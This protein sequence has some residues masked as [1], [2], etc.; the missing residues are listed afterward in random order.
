[1]KRILL[2]IIVIAG[3]NIANAQVSFTATISSVGGNCGYEIVNGVSHGSL[4]IAVTEQVLKDLS[5]RTYPDCAA[6]ESARQSLKRINDNGCVINISTTP[7]T[8][9][10]GAGNVN[11]LGPSQGSSFFS[12]TPAEEIN[13]W[14]NDDIE[15]QLSL[16]PNFQTKRPDAIVTNDASY[17][18][19]RTMER[20][21]S[22]WS[23]DTD[24]PFVPVNMREGGSSRIESKDFSIRDKLDQATD[25]SFLA[26][27][28][29]VQRYV[30]ASSSSSLTQS[31]LNNPQD[32]IQL[33]HKEF[34]TASD[35]DLDAIMQ[36]L[37]SE[38]TKAEKQALIDYQEY[39]RIVTDNAIKEINELMARDEK[40]KE[41]EMAVLAEN[42]YKD[43][44]HA[45]LSQTNYKA[46][47]T[48]F[49]P[50]NSPMR[51][52]SE[53]IDE[54]NNTNSETGFH[55]EIYFNEKTNEYT[56]AFEGTNTDEVINDILKTDVS[57]GLGGVPAQFQLAYR[58]AELI[59]NPGFPSDI[60]INATGHSL[61]GGLA[62]IVGLATGI[63]TFTYNAAGVNKNIIDNFG[64]NEKS[65]KNIKAFQTAGDL[66]NSDPLTSVQ[67]GDLKAPIASVVIGVVSI[68]NPSTGGKLA[69][70]VLTGSAAAPAIGNKEK[71]WSYSG[72]GITPMVSYL[73]QSVTQYESMKSNLYEKGHGVERQTQDSILII[74][75]E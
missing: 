40:V 18:K 56:I 66:L 15:R 63:P 55:A 28:A 73:A 38:R 14:S 65:D 53:L 61:G 59:N 22:G 52:L 6:C 62:S 5:S 32:L 1:M 31:Y 13:D 68:I 33:L 8:P 16:N 71:V 35:F 3:I 12:S 46:V 10:G 64:L 11:I 9:C 74:T 70:D 60:K 51:N 24:K 69:S 49:F 19:E 75:E 29:N 30:K 39:R 4:L 25:F 50:E 2:A 44:G 57:L 21:K 45:F 67:E 37:P 36:K 17:N 27:S 43:S 54:Y 47:N 7:C 42:C 34:K 41:F 23:V 72:H 26:N 20:G 58:I 48:D